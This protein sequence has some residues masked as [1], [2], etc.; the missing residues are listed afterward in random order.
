MVIKWFA[1]RS[2]KISSSH[3]HPFLFFLLSHFCVCFVPFWYK[4]LFYKF[5][6][7]GGW[8]GRAVTALWTKFIRH[9]LVK[10]VSSNNWGHDNWDSVFKRWL[11]N[12]INFKLGTVLTIFRFYFVIDKLQIGASF[13]K[14]DN[15]ITF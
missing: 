5:M 7:P 6:D 8:G 9:N 2:Q 15:I 14:K 1:P 12:A 11:T 4:N 10:L 13:T 3:S